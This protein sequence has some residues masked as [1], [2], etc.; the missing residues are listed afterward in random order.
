MQL[1]IQF[2]QISN[3]DESWKVL[4]DFDENLRKK[5][6]LGRVS[7]AFGKFALADLISRYFPSQ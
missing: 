2:F 7:V 3:D 6:M 5:Y 4:Q 1:G